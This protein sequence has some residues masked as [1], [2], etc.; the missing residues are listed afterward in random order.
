MHVKLP[1]PFL[2]VVFSLALAAA[3]QPMQA[4]ILALQGR[5]AT[6]ERSPGQK[7]SLR[8]A[9]LHLRELHQVDI[10]FDDRLVTR[11]AVDAG[12]VSSELALEEKLSRLLTTNG[13]RF[14]KTKKDVYLILAPRREKKIG[15]LFSATQQTAAGQTQQLPA[16]PET[17]NAPVLEEPSALTLNGRVTAQDGTGVPGASVSLKGTTIGTATTWTENFR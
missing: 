4:Q 15:A 5:P 10:V 8:E 9:L 17:T 16:G 2:A 1:N 14:K 12:V 11:Y 13:L 6:Q 7:Q 3:P